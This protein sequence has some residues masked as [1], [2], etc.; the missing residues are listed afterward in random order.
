MLSFLLKLFNEALLWKKNVSFGKLLFSKYQSG[1]LVYLYN[2][3][4]MF[5][6]F[7]FFCFFGK[8]KSSFR[9]N[10]GANLSVVLEKFF[11]IVTIKGTICTNEKLHKSIDL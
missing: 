7:F 9:S 8:D 10:L 2:C 3:P 4:I 1:M 5:D 11:S 6:G